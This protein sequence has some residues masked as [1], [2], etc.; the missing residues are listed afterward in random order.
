[1]KIRLALAAGIASAALV[2][3]AAPA[4][5]TTDKPVVDLDADLLVVVCIHPVIADVANVT[6]RT[7]LDAEL[8]LRGLAYADVRLRHC[9]PKPSTTATVTVTP[10]P[11]VVRVVVPRGSVATGVG[12]A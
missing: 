9:K 4:L 8:R 3:G 1:M 11:P 2:A 10:K 12:P 6:L 5:A 7:K